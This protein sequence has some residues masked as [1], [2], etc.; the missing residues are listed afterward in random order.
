MTQRNKKE[1]FLV[2]LKSYIN[3]VRPRALAKAYI[4]FVRLETLLFEKL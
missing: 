1:W 4:T 3:N 2:M